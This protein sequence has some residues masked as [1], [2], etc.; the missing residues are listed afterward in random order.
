[1]S[2][3]LDLAQA[4]VDAAMKAGAQ[5]ADAFCSTA[6]AADVGVDNSSIVDCQVIRDYGLGVRAFYQ[7]GMGVASVQS[8]DLSEVRRC[9]EQAAGLA[10]LAHPDPDFVALPEP[11]E[12]PL[13][14]DL[15]DEQ[16][17]GLPVEKVVQWCREAIAE[18]QSIDP[19]VRVS[20]GGGFTYGEGALASSTG[21]AVVRAGTK[22]E[23]FIEATLQHD[24][25]VGFY[26]EYDTAR[27]M[28]DFEPA[29]VGAAATRQAR[30]FLGAKSVPTGRMA[31]MLGPWAV[32]DLLGGALGAA[33]AENIQ[34]QRSF[35]AGQEGQRIAAPC[36]TVREVPGCPAGMASSSHDGEGVPRVERKLLDRGTLTTYLHNS[37]TA[38]KA[39][40][41]NTG[42]AVRAGYQAAVGIGA[43]NLQIDRGTR[44][45]AR[46]IGEIKDGLYI[47]Y[48]GLTPDGASG[49]ILATIDFGFRIINGEL[50]YPV[51][52]AMVGSDADE[53]LQQIDEV[54]SDYR[55][56]PGMIVPSL[57]IQNIQVAGAD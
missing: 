57:R 13:V 29:G 9:G 33:S 34:R 56:E 49:E 53:L 42:H 17:A 35:L 20:G 21:V 7:G 40:V 54:S 5:W 36:L 25:E 30:R 32:A 31:L 3:L 46:L 14:P 6:R 47:N 18:A 10:R 51:K 52:T 39:G 22:V 28:A 37:Y 1:M 23:L 26:F 8:L 38:H 43:G 27:R 45:E 4:A 24:N 48:G 41:A 50:A 2:E 15:F 12:A 11:Q 19:A 44:T 55:E 16:V